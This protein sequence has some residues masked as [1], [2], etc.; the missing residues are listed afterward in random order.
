MQSENLR[1]RQFRGG[2]EKREKNKKEL[3]LLFF[4][5]R[6]VKQLRRAGRTAEAEEWIR[7][8]ISATHKK[9]PG[10]AAA[11]TGE[12]LDILR[13]RKDWLFV[14]AIR[15]DEFFENPG[16]KAFE[17]LQRASEK[18]KVW[19]S[20]REAILH[21]LKTGKNPRKACKD[22]PLPETGL[23]KSVSLRGEN[24]PLAA[25]LIEIAIYEKRIDDVLK[26][27]DVHKQTRKDWMWDNLED[28]VAAA[29][30]HEYPDKA[31]EIWKRIAES[32]ISRVN[33]AAYAEG[34]AYLRKAQKIL[35]HLSRA[36]EWDTYLQ[37][38]K[39]ENRRRPRL[40]EILD[41]LSQKPIIPGKC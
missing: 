34:A 22:W 26:W 11:L 19:P 5:E 4:L 33:V 35:T 39:E 9:W 31:V 17:E 8:G 36:D 14:A 29:I 28:K 38:L 3:S 12:L 30:A 16:L 40:I 20:V 1:A 23:E 41:S 2:W 13:L 10:I 37:R 21:F 32:H 15:A 24:P 7:R 25:V 27:Y 6:L 18:A